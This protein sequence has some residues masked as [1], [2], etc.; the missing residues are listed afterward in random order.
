MQRS[1]EF[2]LISTVL[3]LAVYVNEQ[4]L[5]YDMVKNFD[6]RAINPETTILFL[7]LANVYGINWCLSVLKEWVKVKTYDRSLKCENISKVINDLSEKHG[8]NKELTDWLL[9][10]QLEKLKEHHIY[11][12]KHDTRFHLI[13]NTDE[14][15]KEIMDFIKACMIVH[16][17]TLH[18]NVI[19]HIIVHIELYPILDLVSVLHFLKNNLK[20]HNTEKWGYKKLFDY[21]VNALLD[22]QNQGL[23]KVDDWSIKEKASCTCQDCLTLYDFLGSSTEKT[24]IWPL[25]E[26]RRDH[27][28]QKISGLGVPVTQ[29]TERKGS[30]YKL[31]LAKTDKL[32][33]QARQRFERIEADLRNLVKKNDV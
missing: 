2:S 13:K 10:Y 12:K 28:Q 21:V 19:N 24:K 4:Q 15:I 26:A 30:P 22:E 9:K 17:D 16:N 1:N 14:R 23:R 27:I 29:Q 11:Y 3:K 20:S 25:A 32:Y 31:V 8:K 33:H 7:G 6:I 18:A 5:A